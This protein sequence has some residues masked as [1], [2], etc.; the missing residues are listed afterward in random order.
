MLRVRCLERTW[1]MNQGEGKLTQLVWLLI[2]A[3]QW[4]SKVLWLCKFKRLRVREEVEQIKDQL[5]KSET[6]WF[7]PKATQ[8]LQYC[9][10]QEVWIS[11]RDPKYHAIT[12]SIQSKKFLRLHHRM[13]G[14]LSMHILIQRVMFP[15]LLE[16]KLKMQAEFSR[17]WAAMSIAIMKSK[18][19]Y[20]IRCLAYLVV[21]VSISK[22][23]RALTWTTIIIMIAA[24]ELSNQIITRIRKTTENKRAA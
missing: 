9:V 6:T 5:V 10:I 11:I 16:W 8:T 2:Q 23:T 18:L 1:I 24:I 14:E 19:I 12:K 17:I 22:R 3:I 4:R 15:D 13:M 20:W 7:S 21:M